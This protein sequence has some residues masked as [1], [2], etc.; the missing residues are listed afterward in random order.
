MTPAIAMLIALTI[1]HDVVVRD[2]V[3]VIELS[4][5]YDEC[6]RHVFDQVIFWD[7]D[8]RLSRMEVRAWRMVKQLVSEPAPGVFPHYTGLNWQLR[9]DWERGGWVAYG[10]D[11]QA[12][13]EVRASAM[14][15]SWEQYDPELAA[16]DVRPKERRRGLTLEDV[17]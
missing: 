9:R 13:R 2:R 17:K 16:R 8:W 1:P 5:F 10:R 12:T 7:F 11:G 4:H 14:R 3:D 15:E 6:G